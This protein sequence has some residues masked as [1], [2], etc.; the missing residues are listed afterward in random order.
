MHR[1]CNIRGSKGTRGV[2]GKSDGRARMLEALRT[3]ETV[4][5]FSDRDDVTS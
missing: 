5:K 3:V 2:G 1:T 4:S